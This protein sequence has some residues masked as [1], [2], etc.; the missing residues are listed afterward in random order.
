MGVPKCIRSWMSFGLIGRW[1]C[2]VHFKSSSIRQ[3]SIKYMVHGIE[4]NIQEGH[5]ITLR[6][7]EPKETRSWK[8]DVVWSVDIL[9]NGAR[10]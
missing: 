3:Y 10:E 4:Y 5:K 1:S 7:Y 9:W 6:I 2:M 8:R